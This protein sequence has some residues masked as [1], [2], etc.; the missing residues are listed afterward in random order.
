[1]CGRFTQM[2][3]WEELYTLYNLSNPAIS[4]IRPNWN[5]AP[6]QDVGVVMPEDGG[7]NY[8]MMRWGLVP[9]WAKD[10][11]IGNQA[12]NAWLETAAAKPMFRGAWKSRRCLIPASGYYEWKEAGVPEQKKPAKMPF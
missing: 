10:V 3:S 9:M 7:R 5:V 1:M 8:K 2:Y 6:T 12:I 4:N 11:K